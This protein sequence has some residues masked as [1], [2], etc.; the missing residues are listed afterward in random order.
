MKNS[1]IVFTDNYE[2]IRQLPDKERLEV[3]DAIFKYNIWE[4]IDWLSFLAKIA[5]DPLRRQ[6]DRSDEKWEDE[7]EKR[8][9]AWRLWWIKSGQARNAKRWTKTKQTKQ[10]KQT[11]L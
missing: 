7:V 8:R 11:K 4:N 10:T 1:F 3:L 5:F 6:F 2:T 9:I